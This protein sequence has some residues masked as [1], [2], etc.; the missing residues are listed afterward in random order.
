MAEVAGRL[1]RPGDAVELWR[2]TLRLRPQNEPALAA[3]EALLEQAERWPE[4]TEVL[5]ARVAAA[6]DRRERV[7]LHEKLGHLAADRLADPPRAVRSFQSA[8]EID[9][10]NRGALEALRDLHAAR[11]DAEGVAQAWR[12]L[13]PLQE[14][15]AGVKRARLALA[16]VLLGAGHRQEAAEQAKRAF[17]LEPHDAADLARLEAVLQASGAAAEATRATEARAALLSTAGDRAG[18]VAA[19]QA[20]ATAWRSAGR[21]AEAAAA[22]QKALALDPAGR[23]TFDQLRTLHADAGDWRP[24]TQATDLFVSRCEDRATRVALL[25]E[26]AEVQE[27]RLGQKEMAFLAW[28]RACQDAPGDETVRAALERL[29]AETGSFEELVEIYEEACDA[30]PGPL[31]ARTQVRIG[32]L[33]DQKLDD[34]EGAERAFRRALEV[35]P[36]SLAPLDALASLFERRGRARDLVIVREQR[37]AAVAGL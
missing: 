10:R 9:P 12:R 6:Q 15:A 17:D 1:G 33:R 37:V 19:W 22:L 34:P 5:E 28:S 30:L 32:E 35:D 2:E 4:L 3:L 21:R 23:A 8:L 29:A 27:N 36:G 24:W 20:A 16:E 13:I 25:Q 26:L 18:A 31:R 7:R 11:G 14:D